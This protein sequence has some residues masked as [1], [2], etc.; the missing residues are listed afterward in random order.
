MNEWFE[1]FKG[2]ALDCKRDFNPILALRCPQKWSK[3]R[4][5]TSKVNRI[6]VSSTNFWFYK[7]FKLRKVFSRLRPKKS[8]HH[9]SLSD[10]SSVDWSR[11]WQIGWSKRWRL[12]KE[13]VLNLK[14]TIRLVYIENKNF[15]RW[16]K[17]T[18]ER[19]VTWKTRKQIRSVKIAT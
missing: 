18:L 4:L 8:T 13:R 17:L 3:L 12:S 15:D 9:C 16:L 6:L 10:C 19:F 2:C 1:I 14:M 5:K 7:Y 11:I